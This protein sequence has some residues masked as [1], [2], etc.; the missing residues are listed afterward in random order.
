MP[1]ALNR[2]EPASAPGRGLR[3]RLT[4]SYVILFAIVLTA[5]GIVVRQ[6]LTTIVRAQAESVLTEEWSTLLAYLRLE[7]GRVSWAYDPEDPEQSFAL[8][9]IQGVLL[10]ADSRGQILEI[11]HGYRALGAEPPVVL[12]D[13]LR[14]P[15][16]RFFLRHEPA[17][18]QYL[19]RIGRHRERGQ[20]YA[21]ALGMPMIESAQLPGQFTRIYFLVSPL[22]LLLIAILGWFAARRAL[23]PLQRL[24]EAARSV[25]DGNLSLRIQHTNSHDEIG[26]LVIT[27]NRM[28]DRLEASFHQV[29]QFTVDASH[30]LKTPLTAVRGQLEVALLTAQTPDQFR[31]AVGAAIED[32]ERLSQIT[33]N[34][35][36]LARAES[37]QIQLSKASEDLC[38]ILR[39]VSSLFEAAATE[40]AIRL[41]LTLPRAC[42][43]EVDRT[44]F[45]QLVFQLLSNAVKVTPEGGAVRIQLSRRMGEI[46][47]AISDTGPGIPAEHQQRIFERFYRVRTGK[48]TPARGAGLGLTLAS[49]I[50]GA[51][52]GRIDVHSTEGQ[53]ATFLLYLPEPAGS[54]VITH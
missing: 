37:G 21:V 33:K 41:E 26:H 43:L 10:I 27:F 16:P 3:I 15:Q 53:G 12:R 2:P 34:L 36:Q 22:L 7:N 14:A 25:S 51:H 20:D 54:L 45:E 28:M 8:Q 44:L 46:V 50:A 40:K 48:T 24:A 17:G 38:D 18:D 49:W 32:V 9:R 52:G 6:L 23:E 5:I 30:E 11:S 47:L 31:E 29:R 35:V 4:L 1:E 42:S 13:A 19:V 39:E